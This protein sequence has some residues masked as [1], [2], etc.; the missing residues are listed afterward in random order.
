MTKK[1]KRAALRG[2]SSRAPLQLSIP[3]ETHALCELSLLQRA[4]VVAQLSHLLL[5]AAGKLTKEHDD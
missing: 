3:L 1:S 2:V 4:R 5:L